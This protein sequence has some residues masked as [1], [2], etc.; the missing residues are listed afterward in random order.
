MT[1]IQNPLFHNFNKKKT[2]KINKNSLH[3]ITINNQKKNLNLTPIQ[4][5]PSLKLSSQQ[6]LKKPTN[7]NFTPFNQ[8][9]NLIIPKTTINKNNIQLHINNPKNI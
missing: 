2:P 3:S 9:L 5:S 6:Y 4:N 8:Y 7:K 1:F